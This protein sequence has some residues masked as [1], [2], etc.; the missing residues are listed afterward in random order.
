MSTTKVR[1][2][3]EDLYLVKGKAEIIDGEIVTFM[4]TGRGPSRTSAKI[5]ISLYAY[6][7]IND[8]GVA[9]GDNAGFIVD[10]PNRQSFSPDAAWYVG[11]LEE[12]SE[13]D[14]FEGAP[15][16]AAEVRSKNDYGAEAERKMERKRHDYFAAGTLVVWDVDIQG[17]NAVTVYRHNDPDNPTI[18]RRGDVAEA[19]PAVPGWRMPVNDLFN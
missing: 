10:L 4:P 11:N 13:M 7:Q 18:Y 5:L 19:E 1:A 12:G 3:I 14:F 8:G 2:T 17:E 15:L 16:F 9:V 6:E